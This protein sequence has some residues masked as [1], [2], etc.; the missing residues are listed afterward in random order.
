MYIFEFA[1]ICKCV[2][3]YMYLYVEVRL[4]GMKGIDYELTPVV[5]ALPSAERSEACSEQSDEGRD[6]R[7][8]ITRTKAR[9]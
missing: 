2:H 9:T 4:F 6:S 8:H 5:H 1:C 7:L 3:L